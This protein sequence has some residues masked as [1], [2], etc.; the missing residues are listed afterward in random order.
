M[1]SIQGLASAL[2]FEMLESLNLRNLNLTR[3]HRFE[4]LFRYSRWSRYSRYSRWSTYSRYSRWSTYS[5]YSRYSK[6]S[7]AFRIIFFK[8]DIFQHCIARFPALPA[9]TNLD[10]SGNRLTGGLE[11]NIEN[12]ENMENT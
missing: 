6:Y 1:F 9:L 12:I 2:Q 10:I 11:V 5:R 7:H 3:L 4:T 8:T